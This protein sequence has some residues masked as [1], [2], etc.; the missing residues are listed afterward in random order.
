MLSAFVEESEMTFAPTLAF[1]LGNALR[2]R[3]KAP[4][5]VEGISEGWL[6]G[7][8]EGVVS[9]ESAL[10][11]PPL[12]GPM[13]RPLRFPTPPSQQESRSGSGT[14][15][16]K[17]PKPGGSRGQFQEPEGDQG[18]IQSGVGLLVRTWSQVQT[19][20]RALAWAMS[21]EPRSRSRQQG[22]TSRSSDWR[23]AYC[24]GSG[25]RNRR[26]SPQMRTRGVLR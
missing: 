8:S 23:T 22:R 15:V 2:T 7:C 26:A 5:R 10:L 21:E 25:R 12:V 20:P 13:G 9:S 18:E 24:E 6:E 11:P 14:S 4:S 16:G 3:A 1:A 17:G 19:M